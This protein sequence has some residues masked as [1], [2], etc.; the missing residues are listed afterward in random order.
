MIRF[1]LH[2]PH[3]PPSVETCQALH[4]RRRFQPG[5]GHPHRGRRHHGLGQGIPDERAK[6]NWLHQPQE[7]ELPDPN[8]VG[9]RGIIDLLV[10][11]DGERFVDEGWTGYEKAR[12][13]AKIDGD[14]AWIIVDSDNPAQGAG[15]DSDIEAGYAFKADTLEALAEQIGVPADNLVATAQAYN[16][17]FD[18]K[19]EDP[20]G[21]TTQSKDRLDTA[22]YVALKVRPCMITSLVALKVDDQCHVLNEDGGIIE[23]LFATGDLVL[24]NLLQVYNAGHGV[25]NAVY[26]GDIAATQ[27]KAELAR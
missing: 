12:E 16:D 26:T 3:S 20:I 15:T 19:A 27:A 23:N 17:M 13:I 25:G 1:L 21:G 10:N 24:G 11:P 7:L 14:L 4:R 6:G 8:R 9:D 18:G 2:I 22:P 5:D